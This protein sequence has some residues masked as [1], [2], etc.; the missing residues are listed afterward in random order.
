M[1]AVQIAVPR[2]EVGCNPIILI[3]GFSGRLFAVSVFLL[4]G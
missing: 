3:M 4:L 1:T 2:E